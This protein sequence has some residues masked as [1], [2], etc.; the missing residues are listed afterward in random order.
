MQTVDCNFRNQQ[1]QHIIYFS[2]QASIFK[3]ATVSHRTNAELE[4]EVCWIRFCEERFFNSNSKY[5]TDYSRILFESL[6]QA[7]CDWYYHTYRY[8]IN[9]ECVIIV[10]EINNNEIEIEKLKWVSLLE[11]AAGSSSPSF[12]FPKHPEK[13]LSNIGYC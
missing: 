5:S 2:Y 6:S 12:F 7:N 8:N 11:S 9:L 3:E 10:G 1:P 13:K 4:W